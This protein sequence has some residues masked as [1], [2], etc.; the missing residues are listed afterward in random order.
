MAKKVGVGVEVLVSL[1]EHLSEKY[2][3]LLCTTSIQRNIPVDAQGNEQLS[4]IERHI[5]PQNASFRTVEAEGL[6]LIHLTICV[7][8]HWRYDMI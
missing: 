3:A 6:Q 4:Y 7:Q 1:Y 2:S 5:K 8:Y